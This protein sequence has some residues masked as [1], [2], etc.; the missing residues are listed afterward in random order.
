MRRGLRYILKNLHSGNQKISRQKIKEIWL[1]RDPQEQVF[2]SNFNL[3]EPVYFYVLL[4]AY[5]LLRTFFRL[6][7]VK[8]H[9]CSTDYVIN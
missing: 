8:L 1:S 3:N 2:I 7:G 5:T 9:K 4:M 6:Y